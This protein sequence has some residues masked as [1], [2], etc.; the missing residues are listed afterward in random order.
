MLLPVTL[1]LK[2][3]TLNKTSESETYSEAACI[4]RFNVV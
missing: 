4:L 3:V 1:L 2:T